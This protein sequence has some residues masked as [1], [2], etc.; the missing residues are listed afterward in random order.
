MIP[1]PRDDQS[2]RVDRRRRRIYRRRRRRA[3]LVV[4]AALLA[5][6]LYSY[7]T[8]VTKPS[9][10]P[11]SIRSIEWVRANHGAWLVNTVEHYWYS[12]TAPAPGGPALKKLPSVGIPVRRTV[13]PRPVKP[14]KHVKP[15]HRSYRHL[16][17]PS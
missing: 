12:W 1:L 10:L 7:I 17:T 9:S 11:L 8:T 15:P 16:L 3:L 2:V 5:P 4:L 13:T 14:A 6:V